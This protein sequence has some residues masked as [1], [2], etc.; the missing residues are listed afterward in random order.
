MKL[1]SGIQPSGTL[2]LGNYL[3]AVKNWIKL[4]EEHESII[5][6]VN[7]HALSSDFS[8]S[9]LPKQT[10]EMATDL[11]AC[12]IDP[13]KSI[14]FVQSDVPEHTELTWILS[15]FVSLGELKRMTQ[16]K[17]KSQ[18]NKKNVKAGLL[19]YPVLMAADIL[20]YQTQIV[21]VGEDQLQHIEL[22][23]MIARNFNKKIGKTFIEPRGVLTKAPRLMSLKNPQEKMSKSKGENTYI[24]L[25][26]S[27]E[28][29]EKK[30]GSA[31]TDPARKKISDPGTS[32]KCNIYHLHQFFSTLK[33]REE[34]EQGCRRAKIGCLSCKK[35]LAQNIFAE[36]KPIQEK[37]KKIAENPEKIKKILQK[38]AKKAQQIAQKNMKEIKEKVGLLF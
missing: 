38:G 35:A 27:L 32:Q 3:G 22:A 1:F 15:C 8:A 24:A 11:I 16:F 31:I 19:Y 23:R 36:L 33:E 26:D 28:T 25:N 10:I 37:R 12:G 29:I 13:Q 20:L 30:L 14:F 2:H 17:E 34:I 9:L 21:P 18:E 7:Y 5:S 4:Q 6:I